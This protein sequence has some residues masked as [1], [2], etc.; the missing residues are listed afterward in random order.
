[1]QRLCH[2]GAAVVHHDLAG[3]SLRC[4]SKAGR[5]L[6][7]AQ[8]IPQVGAGQL[9]IDKPR[10]AGVHRRKHL[11]ARKRLGHRLGDLDGCGFILFGGRQAAVALKF[12]KIR[13][14]RD[15][16]L[17]IGRIKPSGG[18]GRG[19]LGGNQID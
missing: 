16:D 19:D 9:Q 3:H 11:A 14:V 1:M 13:P 4:Q 5:S 6:H 12:A 15:G 7:L 10:H 8:V 2:I 17:S 18:K